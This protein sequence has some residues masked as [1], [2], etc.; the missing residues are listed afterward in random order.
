MNFEDAFPEVMKRGGFDAIVGNPPYI[1]MEVFKSIKPYLK[2]NYASHDERSDIYTYFIERGNKLIKPGGRYGVIVSNKFL[3]ANYGAPLRDLLRQ[4]ARVQRIVDLAGLPVFKGATVRTIILLTSQEA[5]TDKPL[6]YSPPIPPATFTTVE[7]GLLSV[8]KAITGLEYKVSSASLAQPV[9][10]FIKRDKDDLF[11]KLKERGRRLGDY[12]AGQICMGVKSG[13]TEA[14][15][16]DAA[17]RAEIIG[18]NPEAEQIIKPFLNGRDVRRYYIDHANMFL[19]YTYHGTK[20]KNYPAIEAHLRPFKQRLE[21]RATKQAWYELQQPQLAFAPLM[22]A[23]KIIFPDIAT[24]PRFAPDTTGSYGSNTTYFIPRRD[25]YLLA[26][27]NSNIGQF[28][29]SVVC[30]GLEGKTEVYLRF[31]GQNLEGFH[32]RPPNRSAGL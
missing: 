1:R 29:F 27:L 24:T 8:E 14:F 7:A 28:Y 4:R 26:L 3:R 25:P 6:I 9:W 18:R 11:G 30:A 23:E 22:D 5:D 19:I 10:N 2:K 17:K 16:I 15:V 21:K 32:A 20:I 13:L 12:C 31:F